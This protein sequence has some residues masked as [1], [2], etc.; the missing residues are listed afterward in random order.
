MEDFIEFRFYGCFGDY[1]FSEGEVLNPKVVL[2][3]VKDLFGD[4]FMGKGVVFG[5]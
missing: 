1:L 4:D 5:S 2:Y 3:Q